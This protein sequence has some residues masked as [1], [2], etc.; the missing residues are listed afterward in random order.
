MIAGSQLEYRFAT[1]RANWVPADYA[2][3]STDSSNDAFRLSSKVEMFAV[4]KY[5]R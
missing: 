3:H 4:V 1:V 5:R 2:G